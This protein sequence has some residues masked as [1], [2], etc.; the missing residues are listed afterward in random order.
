MDDHT[1]AHIVSGFTP[2]SQRDRPLPLRQE[3]TQVLVAVPAD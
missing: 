1:L 2:T 3:R